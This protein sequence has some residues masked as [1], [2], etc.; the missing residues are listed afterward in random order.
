MPYYSESNSRWYFVKTTGRSSWDDP[1]NLPPLPAMPSYPG[2]SILQ[3]AR[4]LCIPGVPGQ[5][6]SRN[7]T[8]S[9]E[10]PPKKRSSSNT[11]TIL[12]AASGFAEGGVAGY[13]I[14]DGLGQF[15]SQSPLFSCSCAAWGDYSDLIESAIY[16]TKPA[17]AHT[18]VA[19]TDD[20]DYDICRNYLSGDALYKGKGQHRLIQSFPAY[21]CDICDQGIRGDIYHCDICNDG[22]YDCLDRGWTCHGDGD[23]ELD[24]LFILSR[25]QSGDK[26]S[27]SDDQ[28][29]QR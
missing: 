8:T 14:K 13:S 26:N 18:P 24:H 16:A 12:A 3:V 6:N 27:D 23:H 28:S 17:T 5:F 1:G 20:G 15:E 7:S 19:K 10:V 2:V 21:A 9:Q 22:E 25:T 11:N 4:P 29:I